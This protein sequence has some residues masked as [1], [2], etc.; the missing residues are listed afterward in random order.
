MSLERIGTTPAKRIS[1]ATMLSW[2]DQ[3]HQ[4]L[5]LLVAATLLTASVL[6][7]HQLL[8]EPILGKGLLY[9]RGVLIGLVE[10]EFCFGM[11][12]LTGRAAQLAWRIATVCFAVFAC[13]SAHK[14]IGG[15]AS[16]G[17]FGRLEVNP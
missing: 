17:C 10:L 12:L 9:S 8:T 6:K 14:A 11:W 13:V 3:A 4:V 5:R 7:A 2:R 1:E 15:E 16:C